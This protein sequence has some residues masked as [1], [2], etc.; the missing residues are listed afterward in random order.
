MHG[1]PD[2][3][4]I[5]SPCSGIK[6]VEKYLKANKAI[7][8]LAQRG[9]VSQRQADKIFDTNFTNYGE[10]KR[11]ETHPGARIFKETVNVKALSLGEGWVRRTTLKSASSQSSRRWNQRASSGPDFTLTIGP[12]PF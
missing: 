4:R 3:V 5:A 7:L 8:V 10:F 12:W 2:T 9:F 1:K 6:T 11:A